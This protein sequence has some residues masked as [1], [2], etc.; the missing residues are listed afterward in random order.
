MVVEG[1]GDK[2][3]DC[4]G[5]VEDGREEVLVDYIEEVD[6]RVEAVCHKP[7]AEVAYC[8]QPQGEEVVDSMWAAAEVVL[9][10]RVDVLYPIERPLRLVPKALL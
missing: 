10:E 2:D 4:H 5:T 7:E 9:V 3:T 8:T 6:Q 1:V